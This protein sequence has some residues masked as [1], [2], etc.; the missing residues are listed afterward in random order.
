M[1]DFEAQ[2]GKLQVSLDELLRRTGHIDKRVEKVEEHATEL[3]VGMAEL[4][5]SA[6]AAAERSQKRAARVSEVERRVATVERRAD[7]LSGMLYVG[8]VVL[9][10]LAA[11]VSPLITLIAQR[12]LMP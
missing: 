3:R 6:K 12:A 10:F 11:V 5:T 7:R 2:L 4:Q 9:G 8:G 1:G